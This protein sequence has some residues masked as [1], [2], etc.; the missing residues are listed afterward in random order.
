MSVRIEVAGARSGEDSSG[1]VP[2][3]E[4]DLVGITGSG[5]VSSVHAHVDSTTAS[6]SPIAAV[7]STPGSLLSFAGGL[8]TLVA[9]EVLR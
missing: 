9:H 8:L 5:D 2:L 3:S 7:A 6:A 4:A 1:V